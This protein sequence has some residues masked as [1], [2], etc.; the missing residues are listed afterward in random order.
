MD[1]ERS[2]CTLGKRLTAERLGP[3]HVAELMRMHSDPQVMAT[4]G[5]LRGEAETL[6]YLASNL[7]HWQRY[8]YGLW[9]FR[10][11]WG[12]FVG[13]AG[14]RHIN[15]EEREEIE[16]AYAVM[17][18]FQRQGMATDI[19]RSLVRLAVAELGLDRL[20]ALSLPDNI[21]SIRVM[22]RAG[23][24]FEREALYR[25]TPCVLHRLAS[26]IGCRGGAPLSPR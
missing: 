26:A 3:A 13:R 1:F 16:L 24:C 23:F 2:F 21:G 9:V 7:R 12:A 4:L 22:E 17:R 15:V 19:A 6:D 18:A 11:A 8:G 20:V 25:G 14:I 10:D 5:G